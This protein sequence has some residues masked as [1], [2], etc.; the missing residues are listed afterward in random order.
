MK[1]IKYKPNIE[2]EL[3]IAVPDNYD[4]GHTQDA[5]NDAKRIA[6]SIV[7]DINSNVNSKYHTVFAELKSQPKHD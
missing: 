2:I 6:A 1:F 3:H 7:N 4:V 5:D